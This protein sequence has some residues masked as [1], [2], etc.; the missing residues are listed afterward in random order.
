MTVDIATLDPGVLRRALNAMSVRFNEVPGGFHL[1]GGVRIDVATGLVTTDMDAAFLGSLRQHYAEQVFLLE[2]E[3][4]GIRVGARTRLTNGD[5]VIRC[6]SW[7]ASEKSSDPLSGRS[8]AC[9]T[10]L[11]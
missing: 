5:L 9:A 11:E 3:R 7:S 4:R 10:P 8:I 6:R 2:A 1:D